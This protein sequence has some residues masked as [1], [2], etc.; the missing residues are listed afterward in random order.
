[1]KNYFITGGT[2]SFGKMFSEVLIKKKLA[3]KIVIYSR[4]EFKQDEMKRLEY[5]RKNENKFRFFLGDV[6]DRDRLMYAINDQIDCVIHTAALKQVPATEYNPFEAVKTNVI[7]TQNL[8]DTCLEKNI[9]KN[10]LIS[11]DKAAS[12]INLYGATKLTSEKLFAAANNHK[13]KKQSI[14]S[15]ARYGN[16]FGSRG[17]VVPLFLNQ[18]KN[19]KKLTITHTKMTR[20]S[21]ELEE[22]I[23]FVLNVLKDM[24]GGEIFVPKLSSYK[25]LDLLSAFETK[26]FQIIGIRDGE[27]IHEELITSQEKLRTLEKKNHFIILPRVTKKNNK[28]SDSLKSYNSNN[29]N[30]F[31]NVKKL[32]H[33]IKEFEKNKKVN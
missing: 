27:K 32:K 4:D 7:G 16:V 23:A 17:S 26:N 20:F 11:T 10:L 24:K 6:R 1:M 29:N 8:I 13:G 31:L 12:P 25:I 18:I 28:V 30:N 2:G 19:K 14:F 5:V 22:A 15:I 3:K 21:I 33:K 9:K